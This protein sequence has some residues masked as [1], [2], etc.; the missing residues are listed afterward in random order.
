M[1]DH[2]SWVD[3]SLTALQYNFRTVLSF[4][5]PEAGVCAVVK[6]DAYGHGA[7][8]CS[9]ALQQEG[10]KWFAVTTTEEGMALRGEGVTARIL[11][12]GGLWR[13]EE[14]AAIQY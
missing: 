10:A 8:A 13:G 4:V 1:A 11:V 3:V 7:G 12:L 14:E 6:S 9:L 5:Q 2:P